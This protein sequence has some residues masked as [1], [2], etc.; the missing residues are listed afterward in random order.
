MYSYLCT[1]IQQR[2]PTVQAGHPSSA[3][4]Y[5][6]GNCAAL[7]THLWSLSIQ[8]HPTVPFWAVI[9]PNSG[10]GKTGS[11]APTEFQQCIPKLRAANVVVLGYVPTSEGVASRRAGVTK[12]VDT[13]A[14]WKAAYRPDGIFFDEVSGKSSDL[15]TYKGFASHAKTVF[16][17]GK[18]FVNS[19]GIWC[20]HPKH[21]PDGICLPQIAMNPGTAPS[22]TQY[23][24]ITDILLTAENFYSTFK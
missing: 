8:A 23:Y 13:Y 21:I 5:P 9:N 11:Q 24:G 19:T 15:T 2:V 10:P 20:R 16:R 12:D 1:S 4:K 18:G 17:S 7:D 6:P 3:R 14:N 22:S